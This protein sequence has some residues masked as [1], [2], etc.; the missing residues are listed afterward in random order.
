VNNVALFLIE[1]RRYDEATPMIKKAI[2]IQEKALGKEHPNLAVSLSNLAMIHMIKRYLKRISFNEFAALFV[3]GK[4]FYYYD[5]ITWR[6]L[7]VVREFDDAEELF[8][9]S[10]EIQQKALGPEHPEVANVMN[11]LAS[12]Y[13]NNRD[14]DE[15]ETYYLVSTTITLTTLTVFKASFGDE[16]EA[17]GTWSPWCR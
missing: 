13:N 16:R 2:T 4:I 7:S 10:L 1:Q 12:C 17:V 8:K 5:I 15:A 11:S 3:F 9:K 6:I 14:F